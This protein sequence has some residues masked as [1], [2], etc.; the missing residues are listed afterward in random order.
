MPHDNFIILYSFLALW[1]LVVL[2]T[3]LPVRRR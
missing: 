3:F 2:A 1:L